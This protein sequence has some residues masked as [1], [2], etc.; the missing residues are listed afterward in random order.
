MKCGI[1]KITN[2]LDSKIYVGQSVNVEKR[3]KYHLSRLK[4]KT[5]PNP[6]LQSSW[7]KYGEKSFRMELIEECNKEKLCIRENFWCRT[8]Q[9][10]DRKKGYNLTITSDS[11]KYTLTEEGR[12]KIGD[13]HRG[14]KL[15]EE[16]KQLISIRHMGKK[17]SDLT[18]KRMSKPKGEWTQERKKNH[19]K[20]RK[21]K[22]PTLTEKWLEAKLKPVLYISPLGKE[23]PY[24][25]V[26]EASDSTGILS[27][28]I[29]ACC[30]GRLKSIYKSHFKYQ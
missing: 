23:T 25:S 1:Y 30:K 14:K 21:G 22:G 17:L 26:K 9:S 16:T 24:N 15:S 4:G 20:I 12:K 6:H 8:F 13:A 10:Y 18:K 11:K 28:H 2:L 19:S 3:W 27:T 29:V 7:N 5:H